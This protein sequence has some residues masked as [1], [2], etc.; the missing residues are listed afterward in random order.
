MNQTILLAG[1][2]GLV[3]SRL[4]QLLTE[5][6]YTVRL[7]TR[8]P[9]AENHF[10][11]DPMQNK[12]DE[13]ALAG[14]HAVINLTGAGIADKRW[15]PSRKKILIDSRVL[16]TQLLGEAIARMPE[17]PQAFISASAIGYYGNSGEHTMTETDSPVGEGFMI[18]CCEAWEQAAHQA[19]QSGIRT[20]I[21]R[22]GVVL[23]PDG[24][25]LAELIK[26]LRFGLGSYF[27]NGK[28]W[29]S[30]IHIDDL[31]RQFI[32][33]METNSVE[34]T[35]NAVA[36]NPVRNLPL[37]KSLASAMKKNALFAPVPA[38]ALQ[39]ALGEMSQVVLNSNRIISDKI[40]A[41][42]FQ[43]K[44]PQLEGALQDLLR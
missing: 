4:Q 42:G 24:G 35:F 17:K 9:K 10:F 2:S 38:L 23:T 36:P 14:V 26:P 25:A 37:V 8:S 19:I 18:E 43:Y 40:Q 39:L 41:A 32:W 27:S 29:W 20:V 34:G 11:W 15:T 1:G 6:G 7:L 22:I 30:W 31:C 12:L 3:G 13:Q 44:H 33:A 28:A 21:L 16:S 5:A